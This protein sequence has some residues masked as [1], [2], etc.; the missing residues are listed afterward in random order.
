MVR[1]MVGLEFLSE[2]YLQATSIN[3][4][5]STCNQ[6]TLAAV[7]CPPRFTKAEDEF[8][9]FF[10]SLGAG[11][12]ETRMSSTHTGDLVSRHQKESNSIMQL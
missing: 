8:M 5:L 11:E 4:Q 3:I 10:N 7:Y 1:H 6:L 2:N 12:Q 9:Q